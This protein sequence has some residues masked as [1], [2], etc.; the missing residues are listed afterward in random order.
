[1]VRFGYLKIEMGYR[2]DMNVKA[3][4]LQKRFESAGLI[5]YYPPK[6][7]VYSMKGSKHVTIQ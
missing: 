7:Q 3:D 2:A 4:H 1:M 6:Q 5:P